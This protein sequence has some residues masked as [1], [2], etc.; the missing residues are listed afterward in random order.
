MK[1]VYEIISATQYEGPF[2]VSDDYPVKFP[3]TDKSIPEGFLQ[4]SFDFNLNEWVDLTP[5]ILKDELINAKKALEE[6]ETQTT[7]LQ[8]AVAELYE[9]QLGGA[10]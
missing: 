4:P 3:F 10:K 9:Q 8:L 7:D 6:Q 2:K 1:E 5:P